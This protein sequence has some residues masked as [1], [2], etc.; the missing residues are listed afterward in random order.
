LR[1]LIR[2]RASAQFLHQ[3][4]ER[5]LSRGTFSEFA[6]LASSRSISRRRPARTTSLAEAYTPIVTWFSTY[7]ARDSVRATWR[8][9]FAVM[10]RHLS[11]EELGCHRRATCAGLWYCTLCD[12]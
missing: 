7:C 10:P 11:T 9:C 2:H 6:R 3:D 5:G 1:S 12:T 8:E 4:R